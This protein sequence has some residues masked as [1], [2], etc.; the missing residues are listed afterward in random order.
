MRYL[1]AGASL[2]GFI[3]CAPAMAAPAAHH[4]SH[5]AKPASAPA[6]KV[7]KQNAPDIG[8]MIALVDKMFPQQPDPIR[9]GWRLPA[10]R[11]IRCG[12]TAA[13]AKS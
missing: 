7:E 11:S 3:S 12:P 4:A 1:V 10:P 2:I 5:A 9:R 6:V 8:A 13:T